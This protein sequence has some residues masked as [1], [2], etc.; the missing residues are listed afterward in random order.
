MQQSFKADTH[1]GFCSRNMLQGHA[2]GAE[3]LTSASGAEFLPRKILH[4][5]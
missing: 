5:I 3:L 1:K 2:P 4:D